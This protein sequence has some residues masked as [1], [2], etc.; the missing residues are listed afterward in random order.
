MRMRVIQRMGKKP[1]NTLFSVDKFKAGSQRSEHWLHIPSAMRSTI[2]CASEVF[3]A[4]GMPLPDLV[5]VDNVADLYELFTYKD[6]CSLAHRA[7]HAPSAVASFVA[8][9]LCYGGSTEASDWQF[10]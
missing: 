1:P 2:I 4:Q 3:A 9:E 10:P 5:G 8:A 6:I 7:F